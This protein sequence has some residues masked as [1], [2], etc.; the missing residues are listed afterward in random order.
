MSVTSGEVT[1]LKRLQQA[2]QYL[3][4]AST[5]PTTNEA[6]RDEITHNLAMVRKL[7]Q[8]AQQQNNQQQNQEQQAESEKQQENQQQQNSTWANQQ[9]QPQDS[10]NQE[11][12]LSEAMKQQLEQYQ[13]Q[14]LGE[15][16]Q[17]QQFFDKRPPE[18]DQNDPF[19]RLQELFGGDPQLKQDL[20]WSWTKDW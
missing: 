4:W 12:Q 9:E 6:H 16:A 13:Q 19:N 15:Q 2:E 11:Q 18:S 8:E 10:Q 20:W 7:L 17:N 1:D 5:L 3:S 14:L